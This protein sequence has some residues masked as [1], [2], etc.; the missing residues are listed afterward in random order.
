MPCCTSVRWMDVDAAFID[1]AIDLRFL[2]AAAFEGSS[3]SSSHKLL[4]ISLDAFWQGPCCNASY[5]NSGVWAIQSS[6]RALDLL[7]AWWDA[8][9]RYHEPGMKREGRGVLNMWDQGAINR[10]FMEA[11]LRGG[12]Q[13][14]PHCHFYGYPWHLLDRPFL[15]HLAG[16]KRMNLDLNYR[17]FKFWDEHL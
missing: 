1:H 13:E 4:H 16:T 15:A 12:I 6:L 14:H 2:L 9:A 7:S 17:Y 10:L 11:D 5:L 3:S 8:P